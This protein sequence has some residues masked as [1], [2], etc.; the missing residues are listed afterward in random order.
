ETVIRLADYIRSL[1]YACKVEH[2][3]GDTDLLHVPIALKAGFG[4]LGRHGSIIHPKLGPLFRMGSVL[5]SLELATESAD[6]RRDRRVLRSLQGLPALL[7][8]RR[9]SRPAQP[10]RGEGS[11]RERS[12]RRRHRAVFSVLCQALLLL[13]LP[14]GLRIQPQGVGAGLRGVRDQAVSEGDHGGAAGAGRSGGCGAAAPVSAAQ[15]LIAARLGDGA[16]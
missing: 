6:R 16:R 4:E 9:D 3:I 12:L 10:E 5:T 7:P 15:A 13:D 14:A 8:G 1:G 2:P 11:P